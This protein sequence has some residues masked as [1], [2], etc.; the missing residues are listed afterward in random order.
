MKK[1]LAALLISIPTI[2][3]ATSD[4]YRSM[5]PEVPGAQDIYSAYIDNGYTA[6]DAMIF[7]NWDII[8]GLSLVVDQDVKD[9]KLEADV[10]KLRETYSKK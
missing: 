9:P 8:E 4:S 3:F 7:T 10:I 6:V 1:L 5:I 2:A